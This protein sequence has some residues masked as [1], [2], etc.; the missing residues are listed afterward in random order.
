MAISV[1]QFKRMMGQMMSKVVPNEDGDAL[2]EQT[3]A[4]LDRWTA[5]YGEQV[6]PGQIQSA[7]EALDRIQEQ[8]LKWAGTWRAS[9]DDDQ[10]ELADDIA[11]EIKVGRSRIK[12]AHADGSTRARVILPTLA[13][14]WVRTNVARGTLKSSVKKS[15]PAY[16]K[17]FAVFT[18]APAAEALTAADQKLAHV[19]RDLQGAL[20]HYVQKDKGNKSA[21][22]AQAEALIAACDTQAGALRTFRGKLRELDPKQC[23]IDAVNTLTRAIR[24][25]KQ[26]ITNDKR[27]TLKKVQSNHVKAMQELDKVLQKRQEKI[28]REY[29]ERRHAAGEDQDELEKARR[30]R[31]RRLAQEKRTLGRHGEESSK[32]DKITIQK[33]N[34]KARLSA[35]FVD[36][37]WNA[38]KV[39]IPQQTA[40]FS[41]MSKAMPAYIKTRSA[42]VAGASAKTLQAAVK[43]LEELSAALDKANN[44]KKKGYFA[45]KDQIEVIRHHIDEHHKALREAEQAL[46]QSKLVETAMGLNG[47]GEIVDTMVSELGGSAK[48]PGA[49]GLVRAALRQRYDLETLEG[50][51][52]TKA[53]P[54]FYDVMARVP[55]KDTE[56]NDSLKNVE[57][58]RSPLVPNGWYDGDNAKMVIQAGRTGRSGMTKRLFGFILPILEK[59]PNGWK[60]SGLKKPSTSDVFDHI[61]LH[62][63][64]HSVDDKMDF[65]DKR[66]GNSR[67]GGWKSIRVDEVR[68]KAGTEKGFYGDFDTLPR[69][70]LD[71]YLTAVL[72]GKKPQDENSVTSKKDNVEPQWGALNKHSAVAFCKAA[73]LNLGAIKQV[74]QWDSKAKHAVIGDRVYQEAYE[75]TWYRFEVAVR[76]RGIGGYQFRAPGE[77]FAEL[78]ATFYGGRLANNHPDYAWVQALVDDAAE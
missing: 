7:T 72:S 9:A 4:A 2:L 54:R 75:N 55:L 25:E 39:V 5:L 33:I 77:W 22:Q 42:F 74:T 52:T 73:R 12:L 59:P 68:E 48:S 26:K 69:P 47:G 23:G 44:T 66:M 65:M 10:K 40:L 11:N 17:A 31:D 30:W 70:F 32:N 6:A 3:E 76:G 14:S 71:A 61:T 21:K 50:D 34:N 13:W 43:A 41:A 35:A 60:D 45:Y 8:L 16:E 49:K 24:A 57:R 37:D 46:P 63:I 58:D 20:A 67:Y 64:G 62:E 15:L 18:K 36:L 53:L 78:Y 29:E 19:K 27:Q 56:G 38:A 51:M 1:E 28:N